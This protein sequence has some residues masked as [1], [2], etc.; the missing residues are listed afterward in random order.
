LDLPHQVCEDCSSC[1]VVCLNE[2]NVQGK[3]R[4]IIRIHSIDTPVIP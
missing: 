4:D 3:I 2:W 1:Q